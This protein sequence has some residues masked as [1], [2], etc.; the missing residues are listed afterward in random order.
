AGP[1]PHVLSR[2]RWPMRAPRAALVLW[3][4]VAIAAV[5]SAFSA[6]LAVAA[7]LLVPGPDGRPT[8][9]PLGALDDLG[10][11]LRAVLVTVLVATL[12]VGARVILATTLLAVHSG[13]HRAR[14]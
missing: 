3:Q 12:L 9:G 4:A 7:R 14:R 11:P 8:T 5:L 13:P 10:A 1:V 6:G 2:A